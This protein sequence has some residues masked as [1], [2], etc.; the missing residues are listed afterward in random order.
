MSKLSKWINQDLCGVVAALE[1]SITRDPLVHTRKGMNIANRELII[2]SLE[3]ILSVLFPGVLGS[4]LLGERELNLFLCDRLRYT[5]PTLV[6]QA[7]RV[8]DYISKLEG[9]S[10]ARNKAKAVEGAISLVESL[11]SVRN[12]LLTDITAAYEGD[13]AAISRDEVL[14]SYPCIQ[15]IATYRIAHQLY[16][17]GIPIIPRVMTE[18][19]HSKTGIDIHPGARI[20]PFFFIDHG[21]GVVIG[22]TTTIGKRVKIYQ[23]VTL[24]ALSFPKDKNGNPIKG[25]KRHPDIEDNVIIY[26]GATVLGGKT[27]IGRNAVI[28]GNCWITSSV[29][30]NTRVVA[31]TGGH[32]VRKK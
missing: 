8:L 2:S 14:I 31:D 28:G 30:R 4:H 13:P 7:E 15:T 25:I 20:G 6:N 11:P 3:E 21:T 1:N 26:A 18:W 10:S 23:G 27:V 16:L 19:A 32:I 5:M 17:T 29:P 12:T 24:G 9:K 22:E